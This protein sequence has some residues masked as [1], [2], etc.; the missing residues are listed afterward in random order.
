M[1]LSEKYV[2]NNFRN[3]FPDHENMGI[4]TLFELVG[5]IVC[6][7]CHIACLILKSQ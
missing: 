4:D 2:Q 3:E 1:S 7:L 6:V 5:A